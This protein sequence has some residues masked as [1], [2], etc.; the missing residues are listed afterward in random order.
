[1]QSVNLSANEVMEHLQI[2][3]G[4]GWTHEANEIDT[5]C[6]DHRKWAIGFI[7]ALNICPCKG[8][9]FT[10]HEFAENKDAE[11]DREES[12]EFLTYDEVL[13]YI[14]DLMDTYMNGPDF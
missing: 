4:S 7:V 5:V 1:M 3:L 9:S 11:C 10:V 12:N 6:Y 13:S 8:Y 2:K 14:R